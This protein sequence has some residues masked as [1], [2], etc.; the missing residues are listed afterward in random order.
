MMSSVITLKKKFYGPGYKSP[1]VQF[2]GLA[3][4]YT[5]KDALIFHAGCGSDISIGLKQ[6]TKN[7]IGMDREI[8]IKNNSDLGLAILGDLSINLP[9]DSESFNF[10]LARWV[11]EHL[12][13][14]GEF[15]CEAA[16]VLKPGGY[17][18]VLTPNLWNYATFITRMSPFG[19]QKWF[20]KQILH[21]E[22]DEVFKT[23]YCANTRKRLRSLAKGAGLRETQLLMI[24]GSP[25]LLGFSPITFLIG[26][27][28]ERIVMSSRM[29]SNF[30][31]SMLALFS[32]Q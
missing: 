4:K 22:P 31:G 1:F 10:V 24:E 16:R 6:A 3:R 17:L 8:W 11:L 5:N 30:R 27:L 18:L 26:V 29:F 21:Q 12:E 15:F 28:Y 25:N 7:V 14:P 20:I 9:F 2:N 32:K 19:F 23:Y 13:E